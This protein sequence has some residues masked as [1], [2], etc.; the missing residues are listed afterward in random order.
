MKTIEKRFK[1]QIVV[2]FLI[3]FPLMTGMSSCQKDKT[4]DMDITKFDWELK[5]IRQD[6]RTHKATKEDSNKPDSYILRFESDS[7]FQLDFSINTGKG[8]FEIN[9]K[10]NIIIMSYTNTTRAAMTS[11][12]DK[13]LSV[14]KKMT[15][16][17]V[18]GKTLIFDGNDSKVEFKKK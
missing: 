5:S 18:K 3:L 16:Y 17:T 11:F 8:E 15:S 7:I 4:L 1:G 13:L 12:D 6:G 14:F 2:S 9:S 10:G